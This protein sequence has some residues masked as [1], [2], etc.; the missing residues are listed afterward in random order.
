VTLQL[1]SV[2][3]HT[4]MLL[5]SNMKKKKKEEKTR[6]TRNFMNKET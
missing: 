4:N 3:V 6:E 2:G 1:A 5:E